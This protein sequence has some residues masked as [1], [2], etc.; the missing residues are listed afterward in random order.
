MGE[1]VGLWG[2]EEWIWCAQGQ[3]P[4]EQSNLGWKWCERHPQQF[5]RTLVPRLRTMERTTTTACNKTTAASATTARSERRPGESIKYVA[6]NMLN[7]L[8]IYTKKL[9]CPVIRAHGSFLV[10]VA[11]TGKRSPVFTNIHVFLM[12]WHNARP[13]QDNIDRCGRKTVSHWVF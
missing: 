5:M 6:N 4:K 8:Q 13:A 2:K 1:V 11:K 7:M 12:V 9:F 3:R 10:S